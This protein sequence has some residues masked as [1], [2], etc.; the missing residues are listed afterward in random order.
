M[1][2]KDYFLKAKHI[3]LKRIFKVG[4]RRKCRWWPAVLLIF[5][6][7]F[8]R[9]QELIFW[10]VLEKN[11]I[12]SKNL[13]NQTNPSKSSLSNTVL[14]LLLAS[15]RSWK[16]FETINFLPSFW[17]FWVS[18]LSLWARTWFQKS[19]LNF[20]EKQDLHRSFWQEKQ[21]FCGLPCDNHGK[22]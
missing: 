14:E 12:T 19:W 17:I 2:I 9:N 20:Q 16:P 15:S 1:Q 5:I 11:S 3:F 22:C 18:W 6:Q 10:I 13:R 7:L 8:Y 4:G 21:D